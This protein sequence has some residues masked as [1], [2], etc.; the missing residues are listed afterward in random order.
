MPESNQRIPA[1]AAWFKQRVRVAAAKIEKQGYSYDELDLCLTE[2]T[3]KGHLSHGDSV[4]A[5]L[6]LNTSLDV[7]S[8]NEPHAAH[9]S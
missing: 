4:L 2:G 5:P 6:R 7:C 8:W 1:P 9:S 3:S